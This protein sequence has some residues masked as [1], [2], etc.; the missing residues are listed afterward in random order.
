MPRPKDIQLKKKKEKVLKNIVSV[1]RS[2]GKYGEIP[3]R[4]FFDEID[5]VRHIW[6]SPSYFIRELKEYLPSDIMVESKQKKGTFLRVKNNHKVIKLRSPKGRKEFIGTAIMA[7]P[8]TAKRIPTSRVP[9]MIKSL[10][11]EEVYRVEKGYIVKNNDET[12]LFV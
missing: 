12:I 11:P 3:A 6:R 2:A 5:E 1:I 8:P 4:R 7:V 9:K 10:N